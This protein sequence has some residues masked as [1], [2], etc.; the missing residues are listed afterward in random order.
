MSRIEL[1]SP[2]LANQI[3]AGEV[4]ER[5]A[6][7][8]KELLENSLDAGATR[9]DIDVEQ[10]GIKLLRVRDDGAGIVEADLSLALSRHA[11]SKIR[12]LDDLERVATLGFRGEALASV[13]SVSRLTMISCATGADQ[14][15][16]VETEGRDMAPRLQP[17][18]HPQGTT[19][20]VRD[21]FFNTPARRKFLRTE[22]TEFSHLEEVVKRLALS[23]FDVAFNL[24]HNGRPV[25]GLRPAHTEQ[26]ARRRVATV[27]GPAFVEQSVVIDN[28]RDGLRLWGWVGLPTFSRSQADLQYFFVNGRM[29]RDKLVAHAVRQA[30]RDVL[31][32]GRHP[33][34]V[35]YLEVDPAVVDVNVHPTKHEV[36]F[37]DG[38]MVHDFLFSSL[39]R[40]L[41]EHRPGE[42]QPPTATDQAPLEGGL[43]PGG[44][45]AGVFSGQTYLSLAEPAPVW[46]PSSQHQM[47]ERPTPAVLA[48]AVAGYSG[49]YGK[50][51]DSLSGTGAEPQQDIPPMGYALAQL[52]GVFILAENAAGLVVV[53]MHAAHER[54]T[55]ERLKLA[56]DQEGLRSQPLLVPESV[57]VSEREAD[58]AEEH[59][60]WFARLG[61]SLQRMGPESLAIREIPSLLRQADAIQLV[62]DVVADLM[63]YGTSDRIQAHLNELLGTMACH[64]A[65]R[66]NRRLTL[67]EMNGLLRDMEQTER[68]GQCNHGRPTWTQMNMHELDKLFLRGR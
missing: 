49:L 39:Y 55:Y 16:Q 64:G 58:C 35:L 52:H 66:A 47:V 5:P 22:K 33:T 63:E 1:L 23:R 37:R 15:W 54:I 34:F 12:D 14:A 65:V 44:A 61:F 17:A 67:A 41:A 21:L 26:E 20:E 36:R 51:L 38:R 10:A 59:A 56:M 48:G 42:Q 4:V 28:E 8:I 31:F 18:A 6:S 25:F 53:D 45:D 32:N 19:V 2:R 43:T 60:G 7:V 30:Y 62:R 27:C 11:T 57:A 29:I 24:R 50:A 46:S 68:S 13:S 40:T 9:V 3:A